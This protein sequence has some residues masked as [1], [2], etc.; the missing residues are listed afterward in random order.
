MRR[1]ILDAIEEALTQHRVFGDSDYILDRFQECM[2]LRLERISARLPIAQKLLDIFTRSRSASTGRVIGESV[3]RCAILH[4]HVQIETG[5]PFGLPL[6]ECERIFDVA[7]RHL[8]RGRMETPLADGALRRLGPRSQHGWI[9]SDEHSS[10]AF[11]RSFRHLVTLNFGDDLPCTPSDEEIAR[12][13]AGAQLL[14][15]LLPRLTPSVLGHAQLTACVPQTGVWKGKTSSSQFN[16]GGTIF[17]SRSLG[18]PWWI[19]EHLLHEAL[20]QKLYDLRHGHLLLELDY[21]REG[22][23]SVWSPWNQRRLNDA[24]HWEVPRVLAAFHVYVHLALLS[25]VIE[26]RAPE[27]EGAYGVPRGITPIRKCLERAHYLGEK[28]RE[29]CWEQLGIAGKRL[30]EW[31]ISALEILD[32]T[33][34]PKG[35]FVHLCLDLYKKGAAQIASSLGEVGPASS[36][37]AKRLLPLA[38]QEVDGLRRLLSV[39]DARSE[40]HRFNAALANYRDDEWGSKFPELRHCIT[41]S[42]TN[43]CTDGYR[44]NGSGAHDRLAGEM[45]EGADVALYSLIAEHPPQ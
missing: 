29:T 22:A 24:N 17:L 14:E 45:L 5:Q 26:Q 39:L 25:L 35:A 34:P 1:E 9:W 16:L 4:A 13:Q 42:I 18:S 8:E 43:V 30:V 27:L 31:L 11:G 19:A 44:L 41:A 36:S 3:L 15:Q 33:P 12:L 2:E 28:L 23:P 40:L 38:Q 37:L 20:H 21:L 6:S 32:P 7:V 10:D